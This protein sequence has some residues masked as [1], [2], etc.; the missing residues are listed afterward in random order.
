MF[1]YH[2]HC[3]IS[4]AGTVSLTKMQGLGRM[5]F[6]Q[7]RRLVSEALIENLYLFPS[8]FTNYFSGCAQFSENRG[9]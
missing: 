1:G 8:I 5:L 4:F 9:K 6:L 7:I 3:Q 2:S